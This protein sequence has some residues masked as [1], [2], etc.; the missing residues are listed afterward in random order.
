MSNICRRRFDYS[1]DYAIISR[2]WEEHGSCV[3]SPEYLS[4]NGL[5][6]EISG[7]PVAAGFLYKTDSAICVF[8]WVIVNPKADKK[9]RN[10]ALYYL[11]ETA[12]KWAAR[13]GF[14]MIYTSV[15]GPK[16]V[17]RLKEKGFIETDTG[18]SHLFYGVNNE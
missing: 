5:I 16:F 11:I 6:I 3:P 9:Q 17:E 15:K 8:E 10:Q 13:T 12:Q 14:K 1:K 4:P 2:W 18:Q 7:N